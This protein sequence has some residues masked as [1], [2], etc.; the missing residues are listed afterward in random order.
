M[1]RP[2]I[3]HQ[4]FRFTDVPRLSYFCTDANC[5]PDG[6][7]LSISYVRLKAN[8]KL[9]S[10]WRYSHMQT[11]NL[12][13]IE[14]K[15]SSSLD[16]V[17][18]PASEGLDTLDTLIPDSMDENM[19]SALSRLA[20]ALGNDVAGFVCAR[21]K[22]SRSDLRQ[23]F[24]AEQV[25][26]IA[27]AIYNIES[28]NEA[29]IVGDQTGVG[30]GR[31]AAGIVRYAHS[32]GRLPIFFTEK[33]NLFSDFYRDAKDTGI[34][35]L[36]PF[37]INADGFV[38][39][40]DK[41]VDS[42]PGAEVYET[43]YE[44]LPSSMLTRIFKSGKLPE[45]YDYILCTYSQLSDNKDKETFL[46]SVAERG[47]AIFILDEAHNAAGQSS[48]GD[49]VKELI[50][51]DGCDVVF[52]SATFAKYPKNLL[53]YISRTK[54]RDCTTPLTL[55]LAISRGGIPL[56]ELI[57]SL[58]VESGQMVRRQR[59][60]SKIEVNYNTTDE[61]DRQ[62]D[63]INYNRIMRFVRDIISLQ[64]MHVRDLIMQLREQKVLPKT[65]KPYSI[66]AYM[67]VITNA[68]LL[69]IKAKSVVKKTIE[70]VRNGRSVV[71]GLSQTSAAHL[72]PQ[73]L[74]NLTGRNVKIGD[75]IRADFAQYI[76]YL[77]ER[78]LVISQ[79]KDEEENEDGSRKS[80]KTI[81]D[82]DYT[83]LF[84]E[85]VITGTQLKE[86]TLIKQEYERIKSEILK[87]KFN[88]PL[89]PI[90]LI[91]QMIASEKVG[92]GKSA[93][94]IRVEECTGRQLGIEYKTF[95]D[96]TLGRLTE[97]KRI[98]TGL[99]YND[100]QCNQ[101]DVLIINAAGATGA[102][103]HAKVIPGKVPLE[104]VRQRVMIIAQPELNVATEIQKRGRIN[105]TG[106][107]LLPIYEYVTSFIPYESRTMMMLRKKLKSL[108][109]NTTG[110]QRQNESQ[111]S[112][113]VDFDNKYGDEVVRSWL[114][115]HEQEA[116][117]LFPDT[118]GKVSLT[119]CAKDA[120]GHAAIFD[121]A[122]Q[123]QMFSNII[124]D[125]RELE[126]NLISMGLWDLETQ[127]LDMQ[128]KLISERLL[129]FRPGVKS[130]LGGSSYIGLYECK[131]GGK[132]YLPEEVLSMARA[133]IEAYNGRC[134]I[135]TS[136][137]QEITS[138]YNNRWNSG[139]QFKPSFDARRK[140][141]TD[142]Y[143][144]LIKTITDE[145]ELDDAKQLFQMKL[146][147]LNAD[148]QAAHTKNDTICETVIKGLRMIRIG[149]IVKEF[150]PLKRT[151]SDGT[152]V[153]PMAILTSIT[154]GKEEKDKYLPGK[155]R[156]HFAVAKSCKHYEINLVSNGKNGGFEALSQLC[157]KRNEYTAAPNVGDYNLFYYN[158][159]CTIYEECPHSINMWKEEIRSLQNGIERRY[160]VTGNIIDA[161]RSPL[162]ASRRPQTIY[163]S[164]QRGTVS[165]SA[166]GNGAA[167]ETWIPGLLMPEN[168]QD[169]K[170]ADTTFLPFEWG[171]PLCKV[172]PST[173]K[174][175]GSKTTIF[176][177]SGS[178][179][180]VD[181]FLKVEG[182]RHVMIKYM[183]SSTDTTQN[184]LFEELSSSV[185]KDI[186]PLFQK[187][188]KQYIFEYRPRVTWW[189]D[190]ADYVDPNERY[191]LDCLTSLGYSIEVPTKNIPQSIYDQIQQERY[192][193]DWEPIKW[194]P[195]DIPTDNGSHEEDPDEGRER[196][197]AK[198]KRKALQLA[199][200][201]E[202]ELQL[203][204]PSKAANKKKRQ[205]NTH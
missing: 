166:T 74:I 160:I 86:A 137:E 127:R 188:S 164:I 131:V 198:R 124:D 171:L 185:F 45:G 195:T 104:E 133:G 19:R 186:F 44:P 6:T 202:I 80:Q 88:V 192:S 82:L 150:L 43:V 29:I 162:V 126:K 110:S 118:D 55:S 175:Y 57:S 1:K 27:L 60:N 17:Y 184:K 26:A 190:V 8:G 200:A 58:L 143:E 62:I 23:Y 51:T 68:L 172:N 28:R 138:W 128:A 179:V 154:F 142:E 107:V 114:A 180:P 187:K 10:H 50:N 148:E 48:R 47:K 194:S 141:L 73:R 5:A 176:R 157:E 193:Y 113:F 173:V 183:T 199:L 35:H 93:R 119:G 103:A 122:A 153:Y 177:I 98:D 196:A 129:T 130:P 105:R 108:D 96:F 30:K 120:T 39:D 155:V 85:G 144:E 115:A 123:E 191:I 76:L 90:D 81:F 9:P 53:L 87:E 36:K 59:D 158:N 134:Y 3:L 121:T 61:S 102:S 117:M 111:V 159:D 94:A 18:T 63:D 37:I 139:A 125:Y 178:D 167:N 146:N 32:V 205:K 97:R 72:E 67:F 33:K 100:F 92:T 197:K 64:N 66:F 42:T 189:K 151:Q 7:V 4:I 106:Q 40:Y 95:T 11:S 38:Y 99:L 149:D 13:N 34:A 89:S 147:K 70:H 109:A 182:T 12:K 22:V 204:R 116:K 75:M 181:F 152:E 25:D 84:S 83:R 24:K 91:K 101:L 161:F 54:L 52:L 31:Q 71:I 20:K 136:M 79:G 201:L 170:G 46:R 2:Q 135:S 78:S 145:E 69:A 169:E 15:Q 14:V 41:C 65:A 132:P 203:L 163:F 140:K 56:Q 21:L 49:V 77:L 112:E 165:D 168:T 16:G 156:L 174:G